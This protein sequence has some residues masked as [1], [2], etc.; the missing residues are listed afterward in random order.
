MFAYLI[1]WCTLC[2]RYLMPWYYCTSTFKCPPGSVRGQSRWRPPIPSRKSNIVPHALALGYVSLRQVPETRELKS[3][4]TKGRK[5]STHN[6]QEDNSL[7]WWREQESRTKGTA[8][9]NS[10]SNKIKN[11]KVPFDKRGVCLK[12]PNYKFYIW[13]KYSKTGA[14]LLCMPNALHDNR[15]SFASYTNHEGGCPRSVLN[16]WHI[17][18]TTT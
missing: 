7:T 5:I 6:N 10:N 12:S 16:K 9:A 14:L 3:W 4:S 2:R 11:K 15:I 1:P 8:S 13:T 17:K 18:L